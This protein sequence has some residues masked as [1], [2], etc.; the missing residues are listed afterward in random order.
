MRLPYWLRSLYPAR[1]L[2][3]MF[4]VAIINGGVPL[5]MVESLLTREFNRW[6]STERGH[7]LYPKPSP[8]G[9]I[10]LLREHASKAEQKHE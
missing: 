8:R 6:D 7:W 9:F 2:R 5:E 3:A 1:R 10:N 4:G